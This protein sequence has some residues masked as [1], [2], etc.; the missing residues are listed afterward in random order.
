M[1]KIITIVGA[2]PQFIKHAPLSLKLNESFIH[3]SI[4]TGQHYDSNMSE[5]FFNDLG[6][7]KPDYFLKDIHKFKTHGTQT[8]EML[9]Q[10]EE[11]LVE[12][13]PDF[14]L[15][16]GDTNST[17]AG[18]L[19]AIK[20][21]IKIAHVE[22]G[23]RS[24]NNNMPEEINRILTDRISSLLFCSTE[25]S[26]NNL[27]NESNKGDIFIT[28][29][30]M[31]DSLSLVSSNLKRDINFDYILA[32]IHRPYN[33]DDK[34]R[35]FSVLKMLDQLDNK[36]IFPI[37]PRT[38][39]LIDKFEINKKQ[40][41]NIVF[42]EPSGYKEFISLLNFCNAIITDSGG[43]QK[44]AY[45]LRKKCITLRSETEWLETLKGFWNELV[46]EDL[47][48]VSIALARKP[49]EGEYD[50][51]VYGIGSV[52]DNIVKQIKLFFD[53]Q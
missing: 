29:D 27:L 51:E 32:T 44:E 15:V 43:I 28:G 46:F 13:K 38:N 36:V 21:N 23:L 5:L 50:N 40:F 30:I 9:S 37:H 41:S 16:Y 53:K 42:I 24:F 3:K 47:N 10:I 34:K 25:L 2:R 6:I 7:K 31:K 20:L 17:L 45:M 12:E 1:I 18:A 14:V 22:S 4:H 35:L 39:K 26:E 19:A 11:I 52:S 48:E 49:I 33:T 8:A